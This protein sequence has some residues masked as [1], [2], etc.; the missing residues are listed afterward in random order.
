MFLTLFDLLSNFLD[1][2]K[3][4]QRS[5]LDLMDTETINQQF[6]IPIQFQCYCV[7]FR[8]LVTICLKGGVANLVIL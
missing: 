3:N 4:E 1:Q 6:K 8:F 7:P 2:V 5:K